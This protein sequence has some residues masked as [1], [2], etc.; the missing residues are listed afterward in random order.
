MLIDDDKRAADEIGS[1][2]RRR[3]QDRGVY[4]VQP[5]VFGQLPPIGLSASPVLPLDQDNRLRTFIARL[6]S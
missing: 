3:G 1:E 4:E 6:R 2:F 5:E